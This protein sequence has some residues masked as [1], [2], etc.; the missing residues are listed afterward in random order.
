MADFTVTF[1]GT[2][3]SHGIPVIGCDCPVC[4]SQDLRDK[5]TRCS[6]HVE[7]P[8]ASW[9]VDTG[10]D[11]RLQCLREKIHRLDAV[12]YTH[13][14]T[15]HMMGFDD[16]RRFCHLLGGPIPVHASRETLDAIKHSF[17]FAFAGLNIPGYVHPDPHE[18][19]GPFQI[20]E[21]R[22]IPV[23]LEH[24]RMVCNGYLFERRGRKLFAYLTDCKVIPESSYELVEGVD[25]VVLDALRWKQHWTHMTLEE[26]SEAARRIGARQTYFTHMCHDIP[27][28]ET[29]EKLDANV[30]LAY[31]G[32]RIPF[33]P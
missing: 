2:G 20:G 4:T 11:F 19:D 23:P 25:T 13:S 32:L 12:L 14:H 30:A 31:D 7:T 9:V 26:A 5:R 29:G 17:H 1:L 27:H 21:T 22:I 3:T 18:V 33:E 24:G 6:I 16:L 28:Q 8:E 10:P 15:D